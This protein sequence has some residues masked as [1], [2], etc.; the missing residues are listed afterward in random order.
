[1]TLLLCHV[2]KTKQKRNGT[3]AHPK[4]TKNISRQPHRHTFAQQRGAFHLLK[5]HVSHHKLYGFQPCFYSFQAVFRQLLMHTTVQN[6]V[7]Y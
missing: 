3:K 4:G 6:Y 5:G 1:M 7:K 2:F